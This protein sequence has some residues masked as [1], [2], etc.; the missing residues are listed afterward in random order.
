MTNKS[1]KIILPICAK[2]IERII[3]NTNFQYLIQNNRI[4]GNQS[5]FKP[6]VFSINQL[7][8]TTHDIYKS[9]DDDL[10]AKGVF[11]D[12]S[13]AFD[14]VW[15]GGLIYKLKQNEISEK[16]KDN[17]RFL[18]YIKKRVVINRRC[19]SWASITPGVAQGSILWSLFFLIYL[20]IYQ[21]TYHQTQS[22]LLMVRLFFPL[23]II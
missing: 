16:I 22:Y 17:K 2:I 23:F 6:L 9:L 10:E 4:T 5:V 19:L 7:L 11:L 14:K 21:K 20:M 13:K 3:Y 12:I 1:W 18:R 8:S 15:H